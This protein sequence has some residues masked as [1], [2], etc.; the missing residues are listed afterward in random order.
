VL[1]GVA[2]AGRD[3]YDPYKDWPAGSYV[4]AASRTASSDSRAA[5]SAPPTV[6][7]EATNHHRGGHAPDLGTDDAERTRGEGRGQRAV[8]PR[9]Q[10]PGAVRAHHADEQPQVAEQDRRD[11]EH[12]RAA[13]ALVGVGRQL[14]ERLAFVVA[15]EVAHE[16]EQGLAKPP[17][18]MHGAERRQRDHGDPEDRADLLR[19]GFGRRSARADP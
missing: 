9:G 4:Y 2:M 1:V 6:A 11:E 14:L 19:R 10:T 12:R 18:E 3:V 15:D 16:V 13:G 5:P 8:Q 7:S 17:P